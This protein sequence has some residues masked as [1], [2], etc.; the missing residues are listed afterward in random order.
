MKIN[1]RHKRQSELGIELFC[2]CELQRENAIEFSQMVEFLR[3][4]FLSGMNNIRL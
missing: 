4:I 3:I 1:T 2:R